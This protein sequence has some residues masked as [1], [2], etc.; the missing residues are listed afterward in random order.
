MVYL[1][2]LKMN[3]WYYPEKYHKVVIQ[4]PGTNHI[5]YC[6][7]QHQPRWDNP[8]DYPHVE[9]HVQ[10]A[11]LQMSFL[12]APKELLVNGVLK[13]TGKRMYGGLYFLRD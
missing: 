12:S 11:A 4:I 2:G 1:G 8:Q 5:S 10:Q 3:K 13:K 6:F 9:Y 7:I